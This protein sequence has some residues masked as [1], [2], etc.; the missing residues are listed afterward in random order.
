MK[1]CRQSDSF[2]YSIYM[3]RNKKQEAFVN[4]IKQLR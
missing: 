4:A 1:Q 3:T 2:G